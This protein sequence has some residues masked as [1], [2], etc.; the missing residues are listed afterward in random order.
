MKLRSGN[1]GTATSER[2]P[3]SSRMTCCAIDDSPPSIA[4][5]SVARRSI[6]VRSPLTQ[7]SA[8][9]FGRTSPVAI[10]MKRT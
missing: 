10:G 5:S 2:S 6:S 4:A 8:R 1:T 9:S 3:R 7:V